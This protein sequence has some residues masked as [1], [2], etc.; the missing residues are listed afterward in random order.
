MWVRAQ[1]DYLR[2]LPNDNEKR[3]ALK[4]L[5]PDLPK[6]YVRILEI[7]DR[8]YPPQ[9]TKFIQRLL[10]WLVIQKIS[11]SSI[12]FG[13]MDQ[14][15][16]PQ[17]LCQ[18]ICIQHES[19]RLSDSEVPTEQQIIEWLGCL[20]TISDGK[21]RL[22]HFTIKKFLRMD[23]ETVDSAVARR[24]LV[25][26][27]DYN[28]LTQICLTYLMHERFRGVK[29]FDLNQ[30]RSFLEDHPLYSMAA[31]YLCDY[32][33]EL[34]HFSADMNQKVKC[35]MQKFLSTPIHEAFIL[36]D[37]CH[38]VMSPMM[39]L[40]RIGWLGPTV[41]EIGG[42]LSPLHFASLMGLADQVQRLC[43]DGQDPNC[44]SLPI[45]ANLGLAY[46]PL[47]LALV[48]NKFGSSGRRS[49]F[50]KQQMWWSTV[51]HSPLD[52]VCVDAKL[53]IIKTLVQAGAN[54]HGQLIIHFEN[55]AKKAFTNPLSLAFFS[56]FWRAACI[57]LDE[58]ADC[59][60]TA[61][62]NPRRFRDLCSVSTLL[63]AIPEVEGW[64]QRAVDFGGHP[65]LTKALEHWRE[66]KVPCTDNLSDCRSVGERDDYL[67]MIDY[68]RSTS[69]PVIFPASPLASPP[70]SPSASPQERFVDAYRHRR[71]SEVR[72][73]LEAE[74]A[75]EMDGND[76][77]GTN[78]LF[79]S[80]KAPSEH[81]RHLHQRGA[82]PNPLTA[83]GEGVLSETVKSGCF[84][85]MCLLLEF[86][87][88]IEQR[89]S[90]GWTPLLNAISCSRPEM[91]KR[92][93][94]EG[95]SPNAVLDWHGRH[96]SGDRGE[97]HR[98][99]F[100][101]VGLRTQPRRSRQLWIDSTPRG[102]SSGPS[103]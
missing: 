37:R 66:R 59:N 31:T 49:Y 40:V 39:G 46:T 97:G 60:A 44:Y 18:A 101:S 38:T 71:W 53:Q 52:E 14:D 102:M 74:P 26:L 43:R 96:L 10:K 3:K 64:V 36:W 6:T 88:D 85:N 86:G 100:P 69:T 4:Q 93:L 9:T 80:A 76:E 62:K 27:E 11:S 79:C 48:S 98:Y 41:S 63:D 91:V 28:Y 54:V 92:L 51:A 77:Q 87:A 73:L 35:L 24:Y 23:P 72:Q 103:V 15:F 45:N 25:P 20:I 65:G 90:G 17:I 61:S 12:H 13:K 8:T 81:L 32:I 7:I 68:S 2:R 83:S 30:I 57:L 95:A 89:D 5:P 16:T 33:H 47:H 1:V 94:S 99:F 34:T 50:M 75:I 29:L 70:L 56:G 42:Y 84:E 19:D 55:A 82:N 58:G 22:S 67:T 78:L 21:F